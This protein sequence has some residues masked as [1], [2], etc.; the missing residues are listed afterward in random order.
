M[1]GPPSPSTT[2]DDALGKARAKSR[3]W[4]KKAKEGTNKATGEEKEMDEAKEES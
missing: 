4:E 1:L 3:Y 2:L